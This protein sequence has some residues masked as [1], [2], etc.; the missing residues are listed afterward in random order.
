MC[1]EK[2]DTAAIAR[3][4]PWERTSRVWTQWLDTVRYMVVWNPVIIVFIHL[5]LHATGLDQVRPSFQQL[6]RERINQCGVVLCGAL[7][8]A[9]S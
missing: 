6:A 5:T 4:S 8:C 2:V 9:V 7:P 3:S 1:F